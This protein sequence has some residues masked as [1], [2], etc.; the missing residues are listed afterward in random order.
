LPC[1]GASVATLAAKES[2]QSEQEKSPC[3]NIE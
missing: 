2:N 3:R 1:A